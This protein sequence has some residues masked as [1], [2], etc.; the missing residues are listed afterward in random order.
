MSIFSEPQ[1][2]PFRILI[3]GPDERISMQMFTSPQVRDAAA[4][5]LRLEE[6]QTAIGIEVQFLVDG[7]DEPKRAN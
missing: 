6:G 1:H 7:G 3:F 4:R 2:W 5:N